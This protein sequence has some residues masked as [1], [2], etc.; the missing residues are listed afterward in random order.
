MVE[1][2]TIVA[3]TG[4]WR[5]AFASAIPARKSYHNEFIVARRERKKN[6]NKEKQPENENENESGKEDADT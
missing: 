6:Q 3:E 4:E 1:I 2:L 5:K